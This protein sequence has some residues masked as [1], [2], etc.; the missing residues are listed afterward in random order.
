MTTTETGNKAPATP[1]ELVTRFATEVLND[2]NVDAIDEIAAADFIELDPVAGQGPGRDGLKDFLANVAFPAFPDQQWVIEEVIAAGEKV[3]SR[4]TWYGTHRGA[5]RVRWASLPCVGSWG[6][7][8]AGPTT[9]GSRVR[10]TRLH[11]R[12]WEGRR[13]RPV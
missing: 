3:V 10:R 12:P 2:K 4:F 7:P 1:V 6:C 8:L 11:R 5:D 13:C 9:P